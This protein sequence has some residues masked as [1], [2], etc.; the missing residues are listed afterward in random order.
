MSFDLSSLALK[1]TFELHLKSP[2]DGAPLFADANEEKPVV[3]NLFGK[4]SKQY[5]RAQNIMSS[6]YLRRQQKKQGIEPEDVEKESLDMLEACSESAVN[7][8]VAGKEIKTAKDLRE[9][10]AD[11]HYDWFRKQVDEAL[12]DNSNFLPQ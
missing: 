4:A 10:Y 8:N 1:E 5:Q 12:A 6:R 9:I 11:P 7:L 2:I 3:V